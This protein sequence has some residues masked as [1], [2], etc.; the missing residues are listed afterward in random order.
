MHHIKVDVIAGDANEAAYKYYKKQEYQD[1]YNSSV[2]V[3]LR[4]MQLEVNTVRPFESRPH[5]DYYTYNNFLRFA[6]QV[7]LFVASWL[8]YGKTL[9]GP[10]I[11]RKLWSNTRECTQSNEKEQAEDSSYPKSI[12][13]LLRETARKGCP[14]P[15]NVDN[16]MIEP[17]RL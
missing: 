7:I 11:M 1:L 9:P 2:A 14:D 4:E 10:R 16:R 6:Q 12:E 15:E 8:F 5:I 3:M 13:V 17:S